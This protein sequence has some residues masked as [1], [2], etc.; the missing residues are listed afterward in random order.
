MAILTM[1]DQELNRLQILNDVLNKR[2]RQKDA[3]LLLGISTRHLQRMIKGYQ[4]GGTETLISSR[5]GKPSNRRYAEHLKEY[6]LFL[7][8]RHYG[9]FGPTLA[10]EKLKECHD[11]KISTEALRQWM[12]ESGLWVTRKEKGKQVHQPRHRRECFGELIQIDGSEHHWFED[13]GPKCTLLVYIDDATSRLVELRFAKSEST[14]DYFI[15]T[16]RY[17]EK[18]GKP[19]AFYSDKHSIFR[20]NNKEAA[21]GNGMTQF[22]RALHE[23]NIE[24]ICA[25]SS[26][27]KG[28]VERMNKTLQD[29]LVKEL[30]LKNISDMETANAYLPTFMDQLN[31]KFG[32][33]PVNN[34]NLH[35]PL[36]ETASDLDDIFSWQ[37]ERTVTNSLTVQYDRVVYLLE[38][39]EETMGLQRK[40]VTIL[41]YADGTL[42]IRHEGRDLPY[43]TFDKV[44]LVKQGEIVPNKRLHAVLQFVQQ[45]QSVKAQQR[46]KHAPV[47][48]GQGATYRA[49]NPAVANR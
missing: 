19:V 22:G 30:R 1:S 21:S 17:I 8:K 41:D 7:I 2:L 14:F 45:E 24:I 48:T 5:R 11:I 49:V 37:E 4:E 33:L 15:S 46:S 40:R 28:R 29:R 6:A 32:K 47:R 25:N 38:P 27:A 43:S 13:R 23:L 9:D 12:I 35:R 16:R 42:S 18:Y 3:A 20:V 44:R 36:Q 34:K 10:S 39:G 26:Q 31:N